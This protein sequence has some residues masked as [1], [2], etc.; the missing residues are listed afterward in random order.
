M[1]AVLRQHELDGH[2]GLFGWRFTDGGSTGL[3][4]IYIEDDENWHPKF[5]VDRYW[6]ADLQAV[7]KMA[8]ASPTTGG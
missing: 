3:V 2:G 4:T 1:M 5:T 8:N 7:A 6:L